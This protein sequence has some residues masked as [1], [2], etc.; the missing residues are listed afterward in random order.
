[1]KCAKDGEK[2][3]VLLEAVLEPSLEAILGHADVCVGE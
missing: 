1:M 3:G 2:V